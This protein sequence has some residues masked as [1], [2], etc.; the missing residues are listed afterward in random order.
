[1]THRRVSLNLRGPTI[2]E[3]AGLQDGAAFT[4]L[5][6]SIA[7]SLCS[8]QPCT[9]LTRTVQVRKETRLDTSSYIAAFP[10]VTRNSTRVD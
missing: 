3:A 10:A 5:G 8:I 7:V 9:V 6:L 2:S 4:E 1:M